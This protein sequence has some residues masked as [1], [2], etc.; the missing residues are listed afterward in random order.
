MKPVNIPPFKQTT[1]NK[2]KS[3]IGVNISR[4][5]DFPSGRGDAFTFGFDYQ[6][7]ELFQGH[8]YGEVPKPEKRYVANVI[9]FLFNNF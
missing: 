4:V 6:Q 8:P 7:Y 3:K 9:V 5:P 2:I 1:E